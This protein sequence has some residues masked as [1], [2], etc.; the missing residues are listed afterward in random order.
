MFSEGKWKIWF[1]HPLLGFCTDRNDLNK[2]P[3]ISFIRN[4][5][6][7]QQGHEEQSYWYMKE[8]CIR[9]LKTIKKL[10]YDSIGEN[11]LIEKGIFDDTLLCHT[12]VIGGRL[13]ICNRSL[14]AKPTD[15]RSTTD[16][17]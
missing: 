10:S 1:E 6:K 14:E 11:V 12:T 2:Y 3:C 7:I 5:N 13:I 4:T 15:R 17:K 8:D 16:Y 9:V